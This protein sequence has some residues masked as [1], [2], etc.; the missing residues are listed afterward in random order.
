MSVVAV[1]RVLVDVGLST[2]IEASDV[3]GWMEE[4]SGSR[5][6]LSVTVVSTT[7]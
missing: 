4:T 3:D 1:R 7:G 5:L 2:C 6:S